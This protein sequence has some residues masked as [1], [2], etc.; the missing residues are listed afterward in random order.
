MPSADTYISS[1]AKGKHYGQESITQEKINQCIRGLEEV[2]DSWED[3]ETKQGYAILDKT[4]N[5]NEV[6]YDLTPPKSETPVYAQIGTSRVWIGDINTNGTF[7]PRE[8]ESKTIKQDLDYYILE[9]SH[10]G[11]RGYSYD[12]APPRETTTIY[13][14]TPIDTT[15]TVNGAVYIDKGK[16]QKERL[17]G[18]VDV[19]GPYEYLQYIETDPVTGEIIYHY[20][21]YYTYRWQSN[22]YTHVIKTREIN[23]SNAEVVVY[24]KYLI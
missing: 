5:I 2:V 13:D 22:T 8:L 12:A 23:L 1:I 20:G 7:T 24:Q 16:E 11:G 14:V 19:N 3:E 4:L 10:V 21:Y 6:L 18:A 15:S 9:E 17:E